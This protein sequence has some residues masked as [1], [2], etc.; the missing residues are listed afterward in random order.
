MTASALPDFRKTYR[1]LDRQANDT[2]KDGLPAGNYT[3]IIKFNYPVA[4]YN[5]TKKFIIAVEGFLGP[6]NYFIA[7]VYL[8]TG[9]FF[10]SLAILMA[11]VEFC[12]HS[13]L[14]RFVLYCSER[15]KD[16]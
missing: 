8:A 10:A 11:I 14:N 6:K 4:S 9:A 15:L 3:L 2:F 13:P 5:S 7:Y 12:P 1:R 16:D